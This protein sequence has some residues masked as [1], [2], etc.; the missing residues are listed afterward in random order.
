[1]ADNQI[2]TDAFTAYCAER[3]ITLTADSFSYAH[4]TGITASAPGLVNKLCPDLKTDK[5]GL[6]DFRE[7]IKLYPRL[8][9]RSGGYLRAENFILFAHPYFRRG[10]YAGNN[11]APSLLDFFWG[12]PNDPLLTPSIA[13]DLDRVQIDLDSGE[14]MERDTWYGAAFN[15]DIATI[16]D[17]VGKLRPPGEFDDFDL[18]FHF[19]STYSLDIAWATK[20]SIKTFYAEE[21]KTDD[22]ITEFEGESYFPAR[23]VHAEYDLEQGHFR[24]FDGAIHFYTLEEYME[25]RDSDLNYNRKNSVQIKGKS[26]KLFK[27]NGILSVKKWTEY[28]SHFFHGDPLIHEYFEHQIPDRIQRLIAHRRATPSTDQ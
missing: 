8:A 11:F 20:S 27:I 6:L 16:P 1:M 10:F 21:F 4:T 22:V 5:D 25:R 12:I 28:V 23:Y 15:E 14:Y 19:S 26:K 18:Q 9:C 2:L 3:G 17:E 7:L 13:L 24:H